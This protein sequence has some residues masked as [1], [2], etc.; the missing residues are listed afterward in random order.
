ML[1][2]FQIIKLQIYK[3]KMEIKIKK[4]IIILNFILLKY[5]PPT[6]QHLSNT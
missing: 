2:L 6:I 3:S 5:N 4:E 1:H